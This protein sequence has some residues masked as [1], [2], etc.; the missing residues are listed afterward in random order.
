MS[1]A[2]ASVA[3]AKLGAGDEQSLEINAARGL[4]GE[5]FESSGGE[6]CATQIECG[7]FHFT[8][9]QLKLQ[10]LDFD[11]LRHFVPLS[12]VREEWCLEHKNAHTAVRHPD[13][14]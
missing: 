11:H 6:L 13:N 2:P 14:G 8:V 12:C 3:R 9:A 10:N 1:D 4:S 7:S 5:S